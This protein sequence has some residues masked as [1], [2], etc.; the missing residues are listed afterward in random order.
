VSVLFVYYFNLCRQSD[1]ASLIHNE[2]LYSTFSNVSIALRMFLCLMVS[3]CSV[4]WRYG[5]EQIAMTDERLS[6]PALELLSV[7]S[8]LLD[9]IHVYFSDIVDTFG[10]SKSR[11]CL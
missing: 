4:E 9:N 10:F 11:K 1:L 7:E 2:G 6:T 5:E 3:N 8:D